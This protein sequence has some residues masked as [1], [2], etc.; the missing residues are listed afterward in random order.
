[1][2]D[3]LLSAPLTSPIKS[4]P[5]N[6]FHMHHTKPTTTITNTT[7]T[8]MMMNHST[9]I[10]KKIIFDENSIMATPLSTSETL[11]NH[12][13]VN[14]HAT[15][16]SQP[17]SQRHSS[18]ASISPFRNSID[19]DPG[20]NHQSSLHYQQ[21]PTQTPTSTTATTTTASSNKSKS[22]R[23]PQR[24]QSL[25]QSQFMQEQQLHQQIE[26]NV[27]SPDFSKLILTSP[28]HSRATFNREEQ[29]ESQTTTEQNQFLNSRKLK[30]TIS[31]GIPDSSFADHEQHH[32]QQQQQ[33]YHQNLLQL[34]PT[35]TTP[36]EK[37][38]L[39]TNPAETNLST[40]I[41]ARLDATT[42]SSSMMPFGL[43]SS[44]SQSSYSSN[45]SNSTN[46]FSNIIGFDQLQQQQQQQN[47]N[48]SSSNSLSS[49]QNAM[50]IELHQ[51]QSSQLDPP[52]S[53]SQEVSEMGVDSV[54]STQPHLSILQS[55][56]SDNTTT[57]IHQQPQQQTQHQSQ[58]QTKDNSE[59]MIDI[60][61]KEFRMTRSS[62]FPAQHKRV[63]QLKRD[64][65]DNN[66][67]LSRKPS[68]TA[69]VHESN[70]LPANFHRS[71]SV[72]DMR[73]MFTH[74]NQDNNNHHHQPLHSTQTMQVLTQI[75]NEQPF[76]VSNDTIFSPQNSPITSRKNTRRS[77][78]QVGF[79]SIQSSED[80]Q[81]QQQHQNQ[82]QNQNI[83]M[84]EA[85]EANNAS[86]TGNPQTNKHRFLSHSVDSQQQQQQQH[87]HQV[88]P[89]IS[90]PLTHHT[91]VQPLRQ[92]SQSSSAIFDMAPQH[93]RSLPITRAAESVLWVS[94]Q[95]V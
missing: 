1:M 39:Q 14:L 38:H 82:L 49:S 84:N 77:M 72:I 67:W 92:R 88:H 8:T 16:S 17:S 43:A 65:N 37:H 78:I 30:H 83:D 69:R 51:S 41:L 57:V 85:T 94:Q 21:T 55:S 11:A 56:H 63:S 79:Q 71:A 42:S 40:P 54:L 22:A 31:A 48:S 75:D 3:D 4:K 35:T 73:S 68:K 95:T 15:P 86:T 70:S 27:G 52:L 44:S 58:H 9:P 5:T 2:D 23:P 25:P 61:E 76:E 53:S 91:N 60:D 80:S 62:D 36:N 10:Q 12:G 81:Q 19:L 18:F 74:Q 64:N 46:S 50:N 26:S 90:P 7:T 66:E 20:V 33:Q 24:T 13:G 45:S 93:T 89:F 6:V 28:K 34:H 59:L 87:Q 47:K 29:Q 32:Q